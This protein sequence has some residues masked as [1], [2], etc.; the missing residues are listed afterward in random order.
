M[1][2]A[3]DVEDQVHK[4]DRYGRRELRV[5]K[6]AS[7]TTVNLRTQPPMSIRGSQ[8]RGRQKRQ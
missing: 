8:V 3:G 2:D 4:A 7:T 1:L 6:A 5:G